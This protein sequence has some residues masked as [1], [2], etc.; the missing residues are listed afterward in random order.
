M[1]GAGQRAH[2]PSPTIS[3]AADAMDQQYGVAVA[4]LFHPQP[5]RRVEGSNV[6]KSAAS[7]SR[8]PIATTQAKK[9]RDNTCATQRWRESK[10]TPHHSEL[11]VAANQILSDRNVEMF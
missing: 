2:Y 1:V 7:G 11:S 8:S 9:S 4:V 10:P 3:A 6:N 5:Q